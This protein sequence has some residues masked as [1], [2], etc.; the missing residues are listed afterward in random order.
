MS[1]LVSFKIVW[2]HYVAQVKWCATM[3]ETEKNPRVLQWIKEE[4]LFSPKLMKVIGTKQ[5]YITFAGLDVIV[6]FQNLIL[7]GTFY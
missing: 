5:L 7:L 1:D 3:Q 4:D 6:L 2:H